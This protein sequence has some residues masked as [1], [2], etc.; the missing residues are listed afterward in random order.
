M[1]DSDEVV[2]PEKQLEVLQAQKVATEA[3]PKEGRLLALRNWTIETVNLH[4]VSMR[5]C[6]LNG[7]WDYQT[8]GR[9]RL[10]FWIVQRSRTSSTRT[11]CMASS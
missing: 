7:L 6:G 8:I 5:A 3:T 4:S 9:K 11:D 2:V 10:V 1:D